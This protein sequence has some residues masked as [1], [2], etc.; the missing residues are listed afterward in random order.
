MQKVV[1]NL[2][3]PEVKE[4]LEEH[5]DRIRSLE[6]QSAKT[7]QML[8]NIQEGQKETKEHLCKLENTT[9][10]SHNVLVNSMNQLLVKKE[11]NNAKIILKILGIIAGITAGVFAGGKLIN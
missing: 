6:I 10:N 1:D 11:E 7:E 2:I 8:V 9:L 5:D 3:D 4:K